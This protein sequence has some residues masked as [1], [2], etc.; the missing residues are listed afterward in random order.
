[1]K[2]LLCSVVIILLFDLLFGVGV[3]FT[4]A[5]HE[6]TE[7]DTFLEFDIMLQADALGTK[8]GDTQTYLIYNTS[9]F[10]DNVVYNNNVT[11]EKGDLISGEIVPGVFLYS[12]PNLGDN[13]PNIIGIQI[14][15]LFSDNFPSLGSQVLTYPLQ[16]IHF[17]LFIVDSGQYSDLAF[18]DLLMIGQQYQSDNE[19]Q[20]YPVIAT[21]TLNTA[22]EYPEIP[23]NVVI[24]LINNGTQ[25]EIS[26][27][28]SVDY[29]YEIYSSSSPYDGFQL[30]ITGI[31]LE[32]KW[33]TSIIDAPKLY[34]LV[35]A[36]N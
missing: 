1:M 3:I 24:T 36:T 14:N 4:F 17:K 27:T 18:D 6:L 2:K 19:T 35:R 21:S 12:D 33:V 32:N 25:I 5:N 13:Q 29:I 9:A 22:L 23:E 10:G 8:L 15:Y 28:G 11:I 7:N 34:Y 31:F 30:N 20:Y 26:W 16:L